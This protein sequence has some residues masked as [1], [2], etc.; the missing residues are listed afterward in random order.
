MTTAT[1]PARKW[2][3]EP[4]PEPVVPVVLVSSRGGAP[5]PHVADAVKLAEVAE[6]H[7]WTVRQ[8]Y[9][10]A[11]I[12]DRYFLNGRLAKAAHELASVAVRMARGAV[13]G[14]AVWHR[15]GAGS[16]AFACAYIGAT[17]YGWKAAPVSNRRTILEAVTS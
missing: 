9:A 8:T 2:G 4:A 6:A 1:M 3:D 5:V 13:R 7:G 12:D 16:W 11:K 14:W 17:R 10:L 15:E